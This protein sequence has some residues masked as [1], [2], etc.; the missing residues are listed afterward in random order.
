MAS[1]SIQTEWN[2]QHWWFWTI[3]VHQWESWSERH[4]VESW[5]EVGVEVGHA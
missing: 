2:Q 3:Y 4:W 5:R 1:L